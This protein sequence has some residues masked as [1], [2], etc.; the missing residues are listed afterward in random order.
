MACGDATLPYNGKQHTGNSCVCCLQEK[1][2]SCLITDYHEILLCGS[3]SLSEILQ[4]G[5]FCEE[6]GNFSK[7]IQA[8]VPFVQTKIWVA[9]T[10]FGLF[11]LD[12]CKLSSVL[13]RK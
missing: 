10:V 2:N 1:L 5:S 9:R 3:C 7:K 6:L 4:G 13:R 8:K 12:Y 11:W